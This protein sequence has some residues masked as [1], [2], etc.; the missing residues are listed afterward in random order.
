MKIWRHL[1]FAL[2]SAWLSFWRNAAVSMAAVVS[3]T[4][5]LCVCGLTLIVGHSLAQILQGYQEKASVISISVADGTPLATV[6]DFIGQLQAEP[7]VASV[8]FHTKAQELAQFEADPTN[9]AL[10]QE[11]NGNPVAARIDVRVKTLADISTVNN[12]AKNWS[13]ADRASPTNYQ[14]DFVNNLLRLSRWVNLAGVG[15]MAVL[16]LASI[17]IVMNTI[18]TAVYHRR[19]EIEVMKLV[20]ASEWFV[21]GPFVLE[22]MLTGLIAAGLA[23]GAL[24]FSYRPMVQGLQSQLFFLPLS[25]DPAFASTLGQDLLWA[26]VLMGAVG[27]YIGVRRFVKA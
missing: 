22:G 3:V 25:Y 5:I 24:L 2:K 12:L 18:R 13:G 20:G 1:L 21:R 9:Q 14:G 7:Y 10:V 19:Q 11:L 27:S 16:V 6:D 8:T 26:G 15:L 4:L 23:L 17:V